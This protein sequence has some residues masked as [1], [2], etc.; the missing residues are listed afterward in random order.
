MKKISFVEK[1]LEFSKDLDVVLIKK[2]VV[3]DHIYSTNLKARELAKKGEEDGTVIISRVQEKGRGRFDR[4]WE[5][6]DGGVYF[7]IILKPNCSAE[8]TT[9]LPLVAALAISKTINCYNLDSKI[10]WPN[11]VIINGKKI[12][13]ILIESEAEEKNLKHV[14]LGIGIN[15]NID[16]S[17]FSEG[18][19]NNTTSMLNEL[20]TPV[21]YYEFLESLFLFLDRYYTLFLNRKFNEI[22]MK[23]KQNSDTLGRKV[24][25]K[26]ISDD[27]IGKV[28]D[29]DQSG[30]LIV[31]TDSGESRKITSGDCIYLDEE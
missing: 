2:I 14:V 15:L 20:K 19:R 6:P 30:F 31:I 25:I 16:V 8:K 17:Y 4:I 13:G 21:D 12:A 10:K 29:I 18:I 3:F 5:S 1:T 24:R 27:I 23:W 7:S 28:Y 11:D 22:L 9:L 26:S